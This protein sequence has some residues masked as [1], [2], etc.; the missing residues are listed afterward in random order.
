MQ[1]SD[2]T[3]NGITLGFSTAPFSQPEVLNVIVE[4]TL[5]LLLSSDESAMNAFDALGKK[6]D[7]VTLKSVTAGLSTL[8]LEAAK[9]AVD[10][11]SLRNVLD[12]CNV[13]DEQVKIVSSQYEKKLEDLRTLLA[14]TSF[15]FSTIADVDWRLDY[16]V[17]SKHIERGAQPLYVVRLRLDNVGRITSSALREKAAAGSSDGTF[18]EFACTRLELQDLVGKL[19]DAV[20]Q[21]E[22]MS[23]R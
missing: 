16:D 11:K 9:N 2:E 4:T 1:L 23:D 8:F 10:S 12:D 19:K 3:I 6:L 20:K 17:K 5:A 7:A 13:S 21:I 22:R 14:K 18:V 15:G